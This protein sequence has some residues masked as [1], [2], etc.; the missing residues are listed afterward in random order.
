MAR[1]PQ[2]LAIRP[3]DLRPADPARGARLMAGEFQFGGEA[4]ETQA[5]GDPWGRLTPSRRYAS[6][7]H[8]F[9]WLRDLLALG[10]DGRARRPAALD[11]V[12]AARS[13]GPAA[14]MPGPPLPLERRVFNLA[15][16][17]PRLTPLVSEADGASFVESLAR[18][19]RKLA[20]SDGDPARA[21]E[22]AVAAALVGAARRGQER[23]GAARGGQPSSA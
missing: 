7:L 21:A 18:Q 6:E 4:I 17:A 19:A 13:G 1:A 5:G 22:R 10:D 23:R 2:R 12:A 11:R 16:A 9:G 8:G 15:C 3:R 20:E 14:A